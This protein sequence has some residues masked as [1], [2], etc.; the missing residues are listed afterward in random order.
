VDSTPLAAVAQVLPC[1]TRRSRN[2]FT[3]V[4]LLQFQGL[5]V[6]LVIPYDRVE[7]YSVLFEK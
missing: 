2:S 3:I 5:D 6:N 4:S 1:P 7:R